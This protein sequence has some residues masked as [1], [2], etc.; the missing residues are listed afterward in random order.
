ME[1]ETAVVVDSA[2]FACSNC[3]EPLG[4]SQVVLTDSFTYIFVGK[5]GKCDKENQFP[6]VQILKA[7]SPKLVARGSDRIN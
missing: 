1:P 5:C 7:L 4:I 3:D 6:L 2:G